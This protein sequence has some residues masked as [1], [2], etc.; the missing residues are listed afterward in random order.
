MDYAGAWRRMVESLR[1]AVDHPACGGLRLS[2]EWK[3][4][5]G[6]ARFSLV[7]STAAAVLLAQEVGR[8]KIRFVFLAV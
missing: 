2:Y 6:A 3:P 4:A 5:D 8:K 7:P 1:A